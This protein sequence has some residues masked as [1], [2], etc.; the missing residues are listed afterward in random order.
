MLNAKTNAQKGYN[1]IVLLWFSIVHYSACFSALLCVYFCLYSSLKFL[2][3]YYTCLLTFIANSNIEWLMSPHI[4]HH[5]VVMVPRTWIISESEVSITVIRLLCSSCCMVVQIKNCSKRTSIV[6]VAT[7]TNT[8]VRHASQL[9]SETEVS[10]ALLCQ[11][12]STCYTAVRIK[13][14]CFGARLLL[15]W[16]KGGVI[17]GQSY[18]YQSCY[19][20]LGQG[21]CLKAMLLHVRTR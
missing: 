1:N 10:I 17:W 20:Y 7:T 19:I 8:M 11:L 18:C 21:C 12:C 6:K 3:L 2:I 14:C 16:E 4:P 9:L 15:F 5:N 13:K